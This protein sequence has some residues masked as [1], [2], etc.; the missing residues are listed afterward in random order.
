MGKVVRLAQMAFILLLFALLA[1][2]RTTS[3]LDV[4][5]AVN[6]K[7]DEV[8]QTAL[9]MD[10]INVFSQSVVDKSE[11][12]TEFDFFIYDSSSKERDT[13]GKP[14]IVA[15]GHFKQEKQNDIKTITNDSVSVTIQDSTQIVINNKIKETT[16]EGTE[17]NNV[18]KTRYLSY[19]SLCILAVI[20]I[21]FL[22]RKVF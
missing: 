13:D 17:S 9:S 10:S 3:R 4:K 19:I 12:V 2:C 16:D 20:F 18:K 15:S 1:S 21:I 5:R 7:I 22:W 14:P 11:I 6:A 8:V